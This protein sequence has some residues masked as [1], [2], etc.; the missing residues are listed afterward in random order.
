VSAAIEFVAFDLETTGR[1]P[2][3]HEIL[4]IG[5]CRFR[6]DG[7]LMSE[8]Q[9]L[10]DP[11]VDI[12]P[13]V[14]QLTGIT[15]ETVNGARP[16]I[17]T[18]HHFLEWSAGARAYLAH[19]AAF[20]MRFLAAACFA[21][22]EPVPALPIIDTVSLARKAFPALANHRLGTVAEHLGMSSAGS[23]RALADAR[24]VM[25]LACTILRAT[26][27]GAPA[28]LAVAR[29]PHGRKTA[30]GGMFADTVEGPS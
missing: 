13:Y 12:P 25:R 3:R 1:S 16:P 24:V 4:E 19:N 26:P 28:L 23:H 5:A 2:Q 30:T 8:F 6:E 17:E 27:S 14:Q 11:G 18:V 7:S 15:R 21:H 29:R 10:A 22:G 9:E 20:D